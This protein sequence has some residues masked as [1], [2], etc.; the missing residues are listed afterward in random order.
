LSETNH[1]GAPRGERHVAQKAWGILVD[2]LSAIATLFIA[3][4]MIVICAD[5]VARN[6]LGSSLPLISEFGGM[7]VVL[8]VALQL[9]SAAAADRLARVEL[10]LDVLALKRPVIAAFIKAVFSLLAFAILA[11]VAWSSFG[12]FQRAVSSQDFI[13]TPGI[14]TLPTWPFRFLITVGM[15]VAALEFLFKAI[16]QLRQAFFSN[17]ERA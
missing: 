17:K 11:L 12:I 5:I 8:I 7:I 10:V 3:V 6:G 4:L 1:L 15:S 2:G 13:G 16:G 14:G 9:P